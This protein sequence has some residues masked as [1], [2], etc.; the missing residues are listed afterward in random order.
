[1]KNLP[2]E[3]KK[4]G[5]KQKLKRSHRQFRDTHEAKTERG[6][7]GLWDNADL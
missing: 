5:T 4:T 7:N 3:E 6:N 1:V 2:G